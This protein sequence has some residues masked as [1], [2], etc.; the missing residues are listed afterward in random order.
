MSLFNKQCDEQHTPKKAA[1]ELLYDGMQAWM[2]HDFKSL[3][4][5]MTDAEYK[6]VRQHMAKEIMK[7]NIK[8]K[9]FYQGGITA[10]IADGKI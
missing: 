10:Q 9:L 4:P 6:K 8:W 7:L 2:D 5:D 3:Y 1:R